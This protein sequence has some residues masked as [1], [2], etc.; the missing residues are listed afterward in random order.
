MKKYIFFVSFY[1]YV[2]ILSLVAMALFIN[3][4]IELNGYLFFGTIFLLVL[5]NITSLSLSV[6]STIFLCI[7]DDIKLE[8]ANLLIKLYQIPSDLILFLASVILTSLLFTIGVA[9]I[10]NIVCIVVLVINGIIGSITVYKNQNIIT[11]P[12]HKF[13]YSIFQFFFVI[14]VFTKIVLYKKISNIKTKNII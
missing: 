7:K 12:S 10:I 6:I 8:K 2:L 9:F 14:E 4:E 11:D 13:L 3:L 5:I 1:P